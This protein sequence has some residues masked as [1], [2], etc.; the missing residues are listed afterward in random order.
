[1]GRL[2]DIF[3]KIQ[4]VPHGDGPNPKGKKKILPP[5]PFIEEV[6]MK[7]I[8][9]ARGKWRHGY[10]FYSSMELILPVLDKRTYSR[11][12]P[13]RKKKAK[14]LAN[15]LLSGE[16]K[17]NPQLQLLSSLDMVWPE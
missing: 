14:I 5:N 12:N 8:K 9:F 10:P 11:R 2:S 6:T 17:I 3:K 16:W 1:M 15:D 13:G 4:G 7:G